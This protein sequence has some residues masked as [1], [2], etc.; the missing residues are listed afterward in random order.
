MKTHFPGCL[1]NANSS[2]ITVSAFLSQLL[3]HCTPQKQT[4]QPRSLGYSRE[5]PSLGRDQQENQL[6]D[7]SQTFQRKKLY[8]VAGSQFFHRTT[9]RNVCISQDT[10]VHF[11]SASGDNYLNFSL[12]AIA[13][14]KKTNK[15]PP[16]PQNSG[17]NP[18]FPVCSKHLLLVWQGAGKLD[19]VLG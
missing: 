4:V 19:A 13:D 2:T 9:F 10:E 7:F 11:F 8:H 14:K 1:I 6:F 15:Q 12:M 16:K 18:G 3:R 17:T 5:H